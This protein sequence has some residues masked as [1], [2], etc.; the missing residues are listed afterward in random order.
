MSDILSEEKA[1]R[2]VIKSLLR[3]IKQLE[4]RNKMSEAKILFDING[5]AYRATEFHQLSEDELNQELA[6]AQ[7]EANKLQEAIA[8]SN[9]IQAGATAPQGEE[10]ATPA[11]EPTPAPQPEVPATPEVPSTPEVQPE[12]PAA[13]IDPATAPAP[14]Q[15]IVLQ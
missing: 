5:D 12:Q 3:H 13:P 11:P 7:N 6:D 9:K 15:P 10:V 2:E 1:D 4:R 14:V 8:Y